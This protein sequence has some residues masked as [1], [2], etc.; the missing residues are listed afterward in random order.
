M[1]GNHENVQG[2]HEVT[3]RPSFHLLRCWSQHASVC[4]RSETWQRSRPQSY[5]VQKK[6]ATSRSGN[7]VAESSSSYHPGTTSWCDTR[8]LMTPGLRVECDRLP[9]RG[10]S[11]QRESLT[12]VVAP[13]LLNRKRSSHTCA[14]A[15]SARFVSLSSILESMFKG[16]AN[17]GR[18]LEADGA[19]ASRDRAE[20]P[21][22]RACRP[23][24]VSK[25]GLCSTGPQKASCLP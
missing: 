6:K 14:S 1:Y 15:S 9:E 21:H 22:D 11:H 5:S 19:R 10:F 3:E 24:H 20:K 13:W 2:T 17:Y 8:S 7:S 12:P 18:K 4:I 25:H 23:E 16:E